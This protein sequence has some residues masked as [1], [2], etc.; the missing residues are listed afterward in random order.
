MIKRFPIKKV[1]FV[2]EIL[3]ILTSNRNPYFSFTL[4]SSNTFGPPRLVHLVWNLRQFD[5]YAHFVEN[6][7][8]LIISS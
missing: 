1:Y 3:D 7:L 2:L 4:V 5:C 8:P 6:P